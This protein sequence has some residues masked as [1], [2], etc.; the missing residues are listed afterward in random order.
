V[1]PQGIVPALQRFV[2]NRPA[3]KVAGARGLE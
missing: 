2:A 3:R 1:L